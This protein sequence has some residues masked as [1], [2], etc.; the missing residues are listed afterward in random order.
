MTFNDTTVWMKLNDM[1]GINSWFRQSWM[2]GWNKKH[3][4]D[5]DDMN[6]ILS[7]SKTEI[8]SWGWTSSDGWNWLNKKIVMKMDETQQCNWNCEI[9]GHK[10]KVNDISEGYHMDVV[11]A[12]Y[13]S[14]LDKIV[15]LSFKSHGYQLYNAYVCTHS[16]C[17]C[18][19]PRPKNGKRTH[20][21][22]KNIS[23]GQ[24]SEATCTQVTL[25]FFWGGGEG[26][27]VG[28][29]LLLTCSSSLHVFLTCSK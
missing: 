11:C 4:N 19:S 12:Y 13:V 6:E 16:S 28:F 26:D 21:S 5:L 23:H 20:L 8:G 9:K 14:K 17:P 29:L 25:V 27:G 2:H 10:L 1:G 24:W 18:S 3:L 7:Q 22:Q 15:F